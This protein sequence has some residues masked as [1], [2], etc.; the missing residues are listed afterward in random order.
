M[1]MIVIIAAL[2]VLQ[3]GQVVAGGDGAPQA[4]KLDTPT[5][6]FRI[7]M[8]GSPFGIAA[9]FLYGYQGVKPYD[10]MNEVRKLGS[11]FTKVYLFWNQ[12]EPEKG[13]YDWTAVDRFVDQLK[14]PDEGLLALFSSSQWAVKRPSS[15][16]PP[17]PAKNLDDYYRF[18]YDVVKHCRGRVRYWQNDSEPNNPIYWSGTKEEFVAQ[19]KVFYKAVKDADASAVVVVGGYDGLFGPPGTFQMPNQQLGL[20]YFDYVLNEGRNAFDVFDLRLYADPYTIVPRV[21]FMRQKMLALGYNKPI[22]STE[23]GGPGLFEFAVNRKYIPLVI[24]WS[25]SMVKGEAQGHEA[26]AK[27]PVEDLYNKMSTLAPET[28]MFMQGCPP[29]LDAKYQRIQARG[30]VMRNIFALSAG[31]QKTIY[32][33]LPGLPI[34]TKD[35]YNVMSLM[36]GKIGMIDVRND[37]FGERTVTANA[38]E[39]MAKAL[40]GVQAVKRILLPDQPSVFFFEVDRGKL[41]QVLVVWDRRDAFTG[42]DAPSIEVGLPWSAKKAIARDALGHSVPVQVESNRVQL[43]VSLTPIFISGS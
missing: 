23:Y 13:K 1:K 9:G 24:S 41:G 3:S 35:R 37:K 21:E 12:V 28:Q 31:V 8:S 40:T 34:S 14:S 39:R 36:Y 30:V 18:V 33:Y 25:Q 27:D 4:S 29:E 42:E 7:T 16:L 22:I 10:F 11:G 19:L 5:K 32:W 38:F 15:L 17:S 6:D 2:F 43:S 20:S 26:P